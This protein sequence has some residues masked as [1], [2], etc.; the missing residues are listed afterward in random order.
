[1]MAF[2]GLL[3]SGCRSSFPA[4]SERAYQECLGQV[5]TVMVSDGYTLEGQGR[6]GGYH[7]KE[8]YS[9]GNPEGD[10]VQFTIEV[11]RGD[12]DGITYI[13][14]VNVTGCSTS[15]VKEYEHYCGEDGVPAHIMKY[16]LKKDTRGSKFSVGKTI[17]TVIGGSFLFGVLLGVLQASTS[18]Y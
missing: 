5:K 11:H 7:D 12:N 18:K 10:K 6:Q 4:S 13:D 14:E 15:N 8:T 1:M 16:Y 17:W 2:G 9:F 3:F